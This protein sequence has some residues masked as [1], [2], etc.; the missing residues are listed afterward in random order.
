MDTYS[1]NTIRI[2]DT[3]MWRGTFVNKKPTPAVVSELTLTEFEN[4]KQGIQVDAV[5]KRD[6]RDG[7]VLFGLKDDEFHQLWCYSYQIVLDNDEKG[8]TRNS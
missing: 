5:Y 7:R 4:E 8:D 6:V 3:V 1:E 2:G